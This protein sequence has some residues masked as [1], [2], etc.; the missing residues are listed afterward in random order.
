MFRKIFCLTFCISIALTT[1]N[2]VGQNIGF[3]SKGP[4]AYL[5]DADRAL[6]KSTLLE[7]LD[8]KADGETIKWSSPDS[9]SGGAIQMRET[10]E[11]YGTTCR[12]IKT[13]TKASDLSGGGIYRLCKSED[14]S[15]R[16]APVRR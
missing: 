8:N 2:A 6:L 11:D 3:L 5:T 10:H 15:W 9:D 12:S 7:A 16:F 1:G 13:E 14:G 4:I